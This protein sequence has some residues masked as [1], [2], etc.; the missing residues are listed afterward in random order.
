VGG[1]AINYGLDV[2][3]FESR[4]GYKILSSLKPC[5]PAVGPTELPVRWVPPY[6]AEVSNG[7]M[8]LLHLF[9]F[10]GQTAITFINLVPK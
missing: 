7:I 4:W 3:G 8:P 10:K 6:N 9:A 5:R 2:P 1:I